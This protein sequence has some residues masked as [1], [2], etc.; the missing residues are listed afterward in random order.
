MI[1]FGLES[2]HLWHDEGMAITFGEDPVRL[3]IGR[4]LEALRL[5]N[6]L[7]RWESHLLDLKEET[8]RRDAKGVVQPGA[9]R[10]EAVARQLVAEAACM[11]NSSGGGALIV[12]VADDA[13]LIGADTDAG[14]LRHRLYELSDRR[15]TVDVSEVRIDRDGQTHRL[16]ILISPP[17]LEPVRINGRITWRVDDKCVEIDAATWHHRRFATW[18]MDW[19]QQPTTEPVERARPRALAL[20]RDFLVDSGEDAAI[21][22]AEASDRDVLRRLNVATDDGYLTNAGVLAFIGRERPCLDYMR[23]EVAGGDTL[24]RVRASGKSLLEELDEVFTTMN[25]HVATRQ[26]L[27]GLTMA[28]VRELPQRAAREAVV[29][30]VAHRDWASPEPT[31]IEHIGRTLRVTSPGGFIGG[32]TSDNILTHPS[33]SRNTSLTQLLADLRIAEREGI[34]VDR[35][36]RDM[37][38]VGHMPPEIREIEGPFVRVSLVCDLIDAAWIQW[39]TQLDPPKTARDVNALLILRKLVTSH[40]IDVRR[41]SPLIQLGPDETAAALLGLERV[42]MHEKPVIE[43]ISGVPDKDPP[44]WTL[45]ATAREALRRLDAEAEHDRDLPERS[46]IAAEYV[47][48]RGRIST[49]ELASM[50]GASPSNMGRILKGLERDGVVEPSSPVRSGRGFF[51]RLVEDGAGGT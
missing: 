40:W 19:S 32:V 34:G 38:R 45:S 18:G 7:P 15:L 16:L 39:L 35:M 41:A 28:Q 22:L 26:V 50:V 49:T 9:Q 12:G 51:Y 1:T 6:P 23:R 48:A 4:V 44:V 3:E 17:T 43:K 46:A 20:A 30:G 8:G 14:W 37:V 10:N 13:T 11:A 27:T 24:A 47:R 21:D 5:G 25:A 33:Q 2:Y 36:V 31:V 29:N 42:T